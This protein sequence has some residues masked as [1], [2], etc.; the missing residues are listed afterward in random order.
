MLDNQEQLVLK[1]ILVLM[2]V[3]HHQVV[4]VEQDNQEMLALMVMP[5]A[6]EEQEI[7]AS[8][9]IQVPQVNQE[10]LVL[11]VLEAI[12]A[13]VVMEQIQVPQVNQDLLVPMVLEAI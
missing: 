6:Q 4:Q 3:E 10:V 8:E 12:W 2:E 13:Q 1:V 5:E 9:Q 7:Q 11:M